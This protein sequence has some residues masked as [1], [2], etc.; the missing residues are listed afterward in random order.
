MQIALLLPLALSACAFDDKSDTGATGSPDTGFL[1]DPEEDRDT[2]DTGEDCDDQTPVALYLSPDDSNSMSSP[3][4]ARESVLSDWDTL[5][6]VGLRK[7]EFMNYYSF[8][9]EAAPKR[10]VRVAAEMVDDGDG[11]YSMQIGVA[12]EAW[13]TEGRRPMNIVFV[14]DT[15]GSM[16]G[17][18]LAL[19]KDVCLEISSQLKAGDVVSAVSWNDEQEVVLEERT[20]SGPSDP[21]LEAAIESLRADGSTNLLAGLRTGFGLAMRN[22]SEDR[23]NRMVLVTDGGVNTGVTELDVIASYAGGVNED[24][25]YL[26]GVGVGSATTYHDAAVDSLT[27]AGKGASVFV[28]SS[29]EAHRMFGERFSEVM[30]VA[31]RDVGVALDLPPGFRMLRFSGEEYSTEPEDVEPQNLSPNDA[32]VF[33]QQ[34]ETCA[35]GLVTATTPISLRLRYKDAITFA[36][37]E[38]TLTTTFGEIVGSGSPVFLKGRAVFEYATALRDWRD[39][40]DKKHLT[41]ALAAVEAAQVAYPRDAELAEI[42]SVIEALR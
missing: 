26:V 14:L 42:R 39:R 6:H 20:V 24:G 4:Q 35:P 16:T 11:R 7:W 18:S 34:M 2:A 32:M 21:V 31:A 25:V 41:A 33:F 22:W 12:S 5:D 15:S 17:S 28:P 38:A 13:T 37:R 23:I 19:L 29:E 3:V 8:D 27:D 36:D 9:Y 40:H 30:G 10:E 1:V